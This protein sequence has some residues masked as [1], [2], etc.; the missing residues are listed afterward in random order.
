MTSQEGLS[1]MELAR[2]TERIVSACIINF[3][4]VCNVR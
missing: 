3:C 4:N 1:S 2:I